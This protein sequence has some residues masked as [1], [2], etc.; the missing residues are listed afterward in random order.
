[1]LEIAPS[2]RLGVRLMANEETDQ[3]VVVAA[4]VHGTGQ[5]YKG[6]WK[7]CHLKTYR[8]ALDPLTAFLRSWSCATPMIFPLFC[9]PLDGN[10][11]AQ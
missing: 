4:A 1:M 9:A 8:E 5:N 11:L 2:L 6:I 10:V 3:V 7:T